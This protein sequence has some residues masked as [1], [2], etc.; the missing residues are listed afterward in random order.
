MRKMTQQLT[1]PTAAVMIVCAVAFIGCQSDPTVVGPRLTPETQHTV[2]LEAPSHDGLIAR[3]R[4]TGVRHKPNLQMDITKATFTVR[5]DVFADGTARG[6]VIIDGRGRNIFPIH[7]VIDV[8]CG[9]VEGN[10]AWI[11]GDIV[12]SRPETEV[13]MIFKIVDGGVGND[14]VGA[15]VRSGGEC[16]DALSTDLSTSPVDGNFKIIWNNQ[17]HVDKSSRSGG[18]T[19]LKE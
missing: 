2:A 18:K 13:R 17:P 10:T 8:K 4:G 6:Q 9:R 19:R 11:F 14:E 15:E 5:A 1:L 16:D 7:I 12:R 3:V